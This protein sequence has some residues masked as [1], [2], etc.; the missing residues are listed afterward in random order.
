[1]REEAILATEEPAVQRGTR[2]QIAAQISTRAVQILH[3]YTGRGP[4]KARTILN[5]DSVTIIL[6]DALTKGEL[7]LVNAGR[8]AE[9]LRTRHSYQEVMGP[10][11]TQIVEDAVGRKVIAFLS[12][13]HANPD[14]AV[15]FFLLEPQEAA[16]TQPAAG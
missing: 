8:E 2:G 6:Q 10:D 11:L 12:D 14:V 15:E 1:M 3:D 7:S 9:V 16:D 13:N 5:H 4:T